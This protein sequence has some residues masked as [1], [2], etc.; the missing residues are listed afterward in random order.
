MNMCALRPRGWLLQVELANF[1]LQPERREKNG[2]SQREKNFSSI[3]QLI[4]NHM[5]FP[6]ISRVV[7]WSP[8]DHALALWIRNKLF[9]FSLFCYIIFPFFCLFSPLYHH[10][11]SFLSLTLLSSSPPLQFLF[12]ASSLPSSLAPYSLLSYSLPHSS[13]TAVPWHRKSDLFL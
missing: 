7:P 10:T 6:S 2:K 12:P 8:Q 3:L 5:Q 13:T 11:P 1:S 9:S 4:I